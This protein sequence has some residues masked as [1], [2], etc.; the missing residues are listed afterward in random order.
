[1]TLIKQ[2][3]RTACLNTDRTNTTCFFGRPFRLVCLVSLP[4]EAKGD[5]HLVI[6]YHEYI[7]AIRFNIYSDLVISR[8]E[9]EISPINFLISLN[10]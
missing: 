4:S 8:N 9:L 2:D 10:I 7:M 1:M 5:P 6:S 3:S